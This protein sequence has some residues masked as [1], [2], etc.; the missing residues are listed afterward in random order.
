MNNLY[1]QLLNDRL[2]DI[3]CEFA[4]NKISEKPTSELRKEK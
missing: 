2:F 3:L 1:E 4:I